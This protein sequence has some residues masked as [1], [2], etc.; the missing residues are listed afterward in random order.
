MSGCDSKHA[1]QHEGRVSLRNSMMEMTSDNIF[2]MHAY[3]RLRVWLHT[4]A[5]HIECL[6]LTRSSYRATKRSLL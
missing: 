1:T 3:S 4:I 2:K 6:P 5:V